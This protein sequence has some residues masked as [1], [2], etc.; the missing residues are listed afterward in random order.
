MERMVRGENGLWGGDVKVQLPSKGKQAARSLHLEH[1]YS[2][3]S[4]EMGKAREPY[5]SGPLK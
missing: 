3:N 1:L 4:T 2:R 5:K